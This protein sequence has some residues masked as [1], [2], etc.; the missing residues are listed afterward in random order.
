MLLLISE[1][2]HPQFFFPLKKEPFVW[3]MINIFGIWGTPEHRSLDKLP[4]PKI[5]HVLSCFPFAFLLH[6]PSHSPPHISYICTWKLNHG[7]TIW[8]K[9][10][11]AIRTI[12]GNTLGNFWEHIGNRPPKKIRPQQN[13]KE[14]QKKLSASSLLIGCMKFLFPKWFVT[15][16][17]LGQYPQYKLRVLI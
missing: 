16:F 1:G 3:P 4:S 13:R 2:G 15:I 11:S 9:K 5:E 6:P 12:I 10:S 14:N 17:N 7:Q 8:D